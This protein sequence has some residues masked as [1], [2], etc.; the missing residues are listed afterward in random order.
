MIN[1]F[2]IYFKYVTL[3]LKQLTEL[4]P[5]VFDGWKV[6]Q[7]FIY[8]FPNLLHE[9]LPLISSLTLS[10]RRPISYRD[11]SIDLLRK[12]MFLYD[13]GL[14]HERVKPFHFNYFKLIKITKRPRKPSNTSLLFD[15]IGLW[16]SMKINI[17]FLNY[18]SYSIMT[19]AMTSS[20]I[21][22]K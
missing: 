13:I 17:I 3:R 7:L 19:V 5:I 21:R 22:V 12:S 16:N 1:S 15:Y 20:L 10:W 4:S 14:R 6:Q 18:N 2:Q 11:Q 8:L 9:P